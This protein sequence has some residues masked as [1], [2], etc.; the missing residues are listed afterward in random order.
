MSPKLLESEHALGRRLSE[1]LD[2]K[3]FL[4]NIYAQKKSKMEI[5]NNMKKLLTVTECREL[6][7]MLISKINII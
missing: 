6:A 3:N 1:V 4:K 7:I 5:K 2:S